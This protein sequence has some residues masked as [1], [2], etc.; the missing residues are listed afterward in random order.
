MLCLWRRE[1]NEI[2]GNQLEAVGASR[3]SSSR[4]FFVGKKCRAI[5]LSRF[6]KTFEAEA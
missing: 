3:A 4:V 6:L 2:L 5:P 1:S